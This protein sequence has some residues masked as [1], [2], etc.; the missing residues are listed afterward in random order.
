MI[1]PLRYGAGM[2]NKILESMV[3]GTPTVIS[4]IAAEGLQGV[5]GKHFLIANTSNDYIEKLLFLMSNQKIREYI[6]Y[7]GQKH[8]RN[9]FSW[10]IIAQKYL[11]IIQS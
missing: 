6:G 7:W 5:D 4:S 3:V 2:Q 10:D 8:I 1:V 11:K 9:M